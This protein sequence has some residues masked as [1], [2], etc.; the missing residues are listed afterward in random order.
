[1]AGSVHM[2]RS[3]GTWSSGYFWF[4][5]SFQASKLLTAYFVVLSVFAGVAPLDR[6]ATCLS[7]TN[8]AKWVEL[9]LPGAVPE[10][11]LVL[12]LYMIVVAGSVVGV[13]WQ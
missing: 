9:E 12:W 7:V 4:L 13:T 1:M 6:A 10:V 3:S 11:W 8:A 2:K 5:A